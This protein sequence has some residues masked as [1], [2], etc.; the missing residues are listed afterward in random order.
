VFRCL[1]SEAALHTS[2]TRS[3]RRS[4]RSVAMVGPDHRRRAYR[5]R[6]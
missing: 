3:I 4:A 5:S 1:A 6:S 2:A